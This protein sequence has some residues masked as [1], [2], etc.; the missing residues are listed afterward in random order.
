MKL[1]G[2]IKEGTW[3]SCCAGNAFSYGS[4]HLVP[5]LIKMKSPTCL[6]ARDPVDDAAETC[7]LGP[8]ALTYSAMSESPNSSVG[9]LWH[10]ISLQR[11]A[12]WG[13]GWRASSG[14][15]R[16]RGGHV[17][18]CT[19]AILG[20]IS[21][22]SSKICLISCLS[23]IVYSDLIKHCVVSLSSSAVCQPHTYKLTYALSVSN[24]VDL[25]VPYPH[26]PDANPYFPQAHRQEIAE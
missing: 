5:T 8:T 14:P 9:E 7:L 20:F 25:S 11:C 13:Q 26:M 19:S 21:L 16:Y 3:F 2:S 4:H 23:L 10:C 17:G 6:A 15:G 18:F 24:Q 1:L 12:V 22:S